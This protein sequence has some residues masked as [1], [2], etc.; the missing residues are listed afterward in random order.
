MANIPTG[1]AQYLARFSSQIIT[2]S[3]YTLTKL[4]VDKSHCFLKIEDY[5]ILCVPFQFGFKRSLF[6]ASLSK[7][8]L[9]FFKKYV[10]GNVGL[11]M[12]FAAPKQ[13]SKNPEPVKFFIRCTLAS[14][15]PMSG[16]DNV[17]VF[18]LDYKT[19]P[20]DL[21]VML[22]GFLDGQDR[23]RT[24]YEDYGKTPF[25]MTPEVAKTLGYNMFATVAEP[26]AEAK[27][28]QIYRISSK[29]IEHLEAAGGKLHIPN[30]PVTY[31]LFFKKYRITTAGKVVTSS[32]L[33]QGLIHTISNLEYS[34]ELV[35][36]VDDYWYAARSNPS[37]QTG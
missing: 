11:S 2:C 37:I 6:I 24:Q 8:E 20:D 18:A 19:T 33:P 34:P 13:G 35:E 21:V 29:T 36:I 27:R 32:T 3:Q 15:S 10:N 23:I 4:G 28:I 12:A 30:T 22:G 26:N 25:K 31:Q 14:L 1:P 7:Q 9:E 5:M 16:R 17:G